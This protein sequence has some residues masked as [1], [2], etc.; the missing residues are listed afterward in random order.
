MTDSNDDTKPDKDADEPAEAENKAEEAPESKRGSVRYQDAETTTPREPTLAEKR[1]MRK[2]LEEEEEREQT[3]V[4]EVERKALRRRRVMI[5]AGVTVGVVATVAVWYAAASPSGEVTANCVDNSDT[6]STN[7]NI[8]TE[9]YVTSHGGYSSG[10]F[11]FLPLST[12]GY[13][14][15]HYNYGGTVGQGGRVSG[16][17]TAAPSGRTTV[18]SS[19]GSTIQRG[20]FGVSGGGKSGGS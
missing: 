16:G 2:A 17:S 7:E 20:G 8:C 9:E 13:Q 18:K 1:A 5:G 11:F 6:L 15:Y 19:S 12:G 4:V 3:E 14:Q 10:G